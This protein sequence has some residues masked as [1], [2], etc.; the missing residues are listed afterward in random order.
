MANAT[1]KLFFMG[2]LAVLPL[3][4]LDLRQVL[5]EQS[6]PDVVV[7]VEVDQLPISV[8]FPAEDTA[9]RMFSQIGVNVQWANRR[10]VRN[11]QADGT[12]CT[13]GRPVEI[14]VRM[15]KVKKPSTSREA[16][17][18]ASPYAVD[19]A[20]IIVYYAELHEAMRCQPRSEPIVLAHILVH[21]IAHVLQ[22]VARHSDTG[23]M[24]AH[25]NLGDFATMK[26]GP[27]DFSQEDAE[28]VHLGLQK[29]RSAAF[30][31][32]SIGK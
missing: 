2:I 20:R 31:A 21:E 1:T 16:Y 6:V 13:A 28:L 15:D 26:Q 32:P 18:S 23:V 9:T 3:S 27:L 8:L 24:Q 5:R 25:W 11:C 14:G 22:G 10:H 30:P 4:A 17:A 12:S 19:G 7:Y 29:A